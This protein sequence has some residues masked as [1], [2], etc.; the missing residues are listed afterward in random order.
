MNRKLRKRLGTGLMALCLLTISPMSAA[1]QTVAEVEAEQN[2][3]EQEKQELEDKLAALRDDEAQKQEYQDTLQEQIDVVQS[4]IDTARKNINELNES[5]NALT[6]KLEKSEQEMSDTIQQFRER[7]VALYKAGSVST[8]EV[9]LDS[10]SFSDFSMRS[11]MLKT[12]SKRD[13]ELLDKIE[14]YMNDTKAEREECEEKKQ[15]VADL[16]KT[17]E[18]KQEELDGLYEENAAAIEQVQGAQ[19]ATEAALEQNEEELAQN[20]QK[21]QD[22][23]AAQKAYEEE[24]RRQQQEAAENGGGGGDGSGA[25]GDGEFD[26]PTGGGGVEGFNPIWPLPG[27]SYVSCYY[28]GYDGHRGMDIA[29]PYGTAIVAAESG[30]VIEANNYDSWGDSWGYYVLI[31]HNGTY[32]TRYAHMS[33]MVVSTGQYVE[34][35]QIIGYEGA[36]GNVTGPHLHFEVYQN[37]SRVDPMNFLP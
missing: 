25:I 18:S 17:L 13:E 37:G 3:L 36:T 15:E 35:N 9:L 31:Y 28:G 26:Y 7:V 6:L 4:Q 19:G 10:T 24:L 32:T 29:G 22:L 5:I 12:M 33:S 27:V 30:T 34:K 1:A 8:L 23:I 14:Q 11:E 2:R 21:M 20:D 16:Q